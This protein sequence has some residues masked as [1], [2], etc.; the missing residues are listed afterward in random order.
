MLAPDPIVRAVN[1]TVHWACDFC[2]NAS[3]RGEADQRMV[4]ELMEAV[5]EVPRLI[6]KW[7]VSNIEEVRT[8]LSCFQSGNWPEAPDLV[9]YLDGR[10]EHYLAQ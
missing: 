6:L 2:R 8:H 3:L 4:Y 5:H 10:L 7:D 1:D 9:A